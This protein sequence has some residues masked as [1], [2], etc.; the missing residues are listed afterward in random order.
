[1][2]VARGDVYLHNP[3]GSNNKLS[4]QSNNAQNQNRLFDSQNNAAGGYQIGDNCNPV[5]QDEDR[6]YDQTKEGAMKGT[7]TFY[8]GSELY[9]EWVVQH[10][11]GVNQPNIICQMVLQ[12]MCEKDNPALRDGTKRGNDNT[13]GGEEELNIEC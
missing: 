3:R 2:W 7:M 6:N 10:G 11:C 9:I 12:Y 13:A 4:E 8:K 5:C 1:A